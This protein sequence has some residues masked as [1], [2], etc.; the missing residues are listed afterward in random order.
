MA[1]VWGCGVAEPV[2]RKNRGVSEVRPVVSRTLDREV[3]VG[4]GDGGVDRLQGLLEHERDCDVGRN[5]AR[6]VVPVVA[7]RLAS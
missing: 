7:L 3:P 1:Y 2:V 5:E 6:S 4:E